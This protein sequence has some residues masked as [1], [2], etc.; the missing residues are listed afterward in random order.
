MLKH[1]LMRLN[2]HEEGHTSLM[3]WSV[4]DMVGFATEDEALQSLAG[5]L[6]EKYR[7][8]HEKTS[9]KCCISSADAIPSANYCG[10]CGNSLEAVEKPDEE[11]FQW[12]IQSLSATTCNSFGEWNY[13]TAD[14][15]V[16]WNPWTFP[17]LKK[18]DWPSSDE[19]VIIEMDGECLLSSIMVKS[20]CQ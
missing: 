3:A 13:V 4:D 19:V 6:L 9:R 10:A 5:W 8:D 15:E 17:P 18:E 20:R 14:D 7:L 12:W 16:V 2:H 11:E 1:I